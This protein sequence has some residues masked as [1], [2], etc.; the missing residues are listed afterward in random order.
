MRL[1]WGTLG[2]GALAGA[3]AL[4][5]CAQAPA[6][7]AQQPATISVRELRIPETARQHYAESRVNLIAGRDPGSAVT[8]LRQAIEEYPDYYEAY[9]LLGVAHMMLKEPD[10]AEAALR[11]AVAM[12]AEQFAPALISLATLYS[13]QKRFAEAEPLAAQAVELDDSVWYAHYELAR[14]RLALGRAE[15][16]LSSGRIVA[17]EQPEYARGR[18]LLGLVLAQLGRYEPALEHLDAYL[19]LA[20]EAHDRPRIAR[21][22]AEI[23]RAV[24]SAHTVA[25]TATSP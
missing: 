14:A 4:P 15:E 10:E 20:P 24:D 9:S 6:D 2:V 19:R 1:R 21:L 7:P 12:S 8:H 23:S 13:D 25:A 5:V 11:T 3:I 22:R 17:R 18:L 16:A